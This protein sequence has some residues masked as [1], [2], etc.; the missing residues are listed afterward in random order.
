M[1]SCSNDSRAPTS[2]A[3]VNQ[4]FLPPARSMLGSFL[5][6]AYVVVLRSQMAVLMRCSVQAMCTMLYARVL[7]GHPPSRVTSN[8]YCR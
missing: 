8:L 5:C 3:A 4:Q 2:A 1:Q 6:T 7:F